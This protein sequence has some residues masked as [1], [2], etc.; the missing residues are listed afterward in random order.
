MKAQPSCKSAACS[1]QK[2]LKIS[3]QDCSKSTITRY[4]TEDQEKNVQEAPSRLQ[5]SSKLRP[6]RLQ[7]VSKT[8]L[9]CLH[10]A[11]RAFTKQQKA[12]SRPQATPKIF[13]TSPKHKNIPPS[14]LKKPPIRE[15]MSYS[16][17]S[18]PSAINDVD[19]RAALLC[20]FFQ[21]TG[22]HSEITH[23]RGSAALA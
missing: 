6:G 21:K 13:K 12:S 9:S 15:N 10:D 14:R 22:I 5:N 3:L 2:S 11:L 17:L 8:P 23:V 4:R 19:D 18:E 7:G 20:N 1:L 16:N